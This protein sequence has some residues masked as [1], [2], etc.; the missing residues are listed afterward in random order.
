MTQKK[1]YYNPEGKTKKTLWICDKKIEGIE[2]RLKEG[3][4][5]A[6]VIQDNVG[7]FDELVCELEDMKWQLEELEKN[8][9][10]LKN[11]PKGW[12][13]TLY[14]RQEQIQKILDRVKWI[15][16]PENGEALKTN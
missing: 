7:R 4:K 10:K 5:V 13:H 6:T 14:A 2:S 15:K 12:P 1:A 11:N 9:A 16:H 8:T 3:E